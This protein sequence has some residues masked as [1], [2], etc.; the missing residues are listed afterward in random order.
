[1][2]HKVKWNV[3]TKIEKYDS[4]SDFRAGNVSEVTMIDGNLLLNVGVTDLWNLVT[5][6]NNQGASLEHYDELH[7]YIGV[8]DSTTAAVKTQEGLQASSNIWYNKMDSGY[9]QV[10]A[11]KVTFKATF[12]GTGSG[13]D[14]QAAFS[15]EEWT[16]ARG[17]ESAGE[18]INSPARVATHINKHLNR[19][20]ESMGTKVAQATWVITVEISL[21]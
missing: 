16:V 14:A 10:T 19:K 11:N 12:T 9:P 21:T 18:D 20:V 3:A 1:M 6:K 2:E 7:T 5:K 8:G 13:G 4:D 15:W 17:V